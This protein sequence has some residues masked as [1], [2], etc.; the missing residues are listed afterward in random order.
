MKDLEN[1]VI[2]V[3]GATGG[4]GSTVARHLA[5]CGSRVVLASRSSRR[6]E[7]L[8]DEIKTISPASETFK[9]DLSRKQTW[10]ELVD[11][12][13]QNYRRLDGLV[14]CVGVLESAE[15]AD[16]AG[17]AIETE[18]RTNVESLIFGTQASLPLICQ[19]QEGVI[20][21]MGSLGGLVPM[22]FLPL[23]CATKYAVRGFS[24]SM[25]E[26]YRHRGVSFC[27]LTIG[28]VQTAMLDREARSGKPLI[29]FINRPLHPD[30]VAEATLSLLRDP[31]PELILPPATGTLCLLLN[32]SPALFSL[33]LH[34]LQGI[35][36]L[37][38]R[39]YQQ[40]LMNAPSPL[41]WENEREY[42]S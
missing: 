21:T 27:L 26:E 28:P 2:I 9:G 29:S 8:R 32:F 1:K 10:L 5:L 13:Q 11:F 35:G 18:I 4:I 42:L 17:N 39:R 14:N 38:L 25:S 36:K 16:L 15:L 24:L 37:R 40:L 34:A 22:P 6:L 19:Q 20:V 23:Y 12:V 41:Q 30:E 3:A 7:L 31:R 33:C